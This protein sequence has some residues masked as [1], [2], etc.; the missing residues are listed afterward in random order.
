M[1]VVFC[2]E[3]DD[4]ALQRH[5]AEADV[6]A[7]TSE[8]QSKSVEGF[9]LVYLEASASGLPILGHRTG[10]VEDAVQDGV[11]GLLVEP[12]DQAGLD[13][14][15]ATLVEDAAL[16]ER[17]GANGRKWARKFS[18]DRCAEAVYGDLL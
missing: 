2:G 14:A 9:G 18:W 12:G 1:E 13:S 7:L 16:R 5:Y 15:L 3:A 6:F 10:G 4:A 8:L 11:T 17:L